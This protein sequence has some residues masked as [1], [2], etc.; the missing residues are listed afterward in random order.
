[1]VWTYPRSAK[2]VPAAPLVR[3]RD[4]G[5]WGPKTPFCGAGSLSLYKIEGA[6]CTRYH[7]RGCVCAGQRVL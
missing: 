6:T 5:E 2:T 7:R 4:H 1:M 3:P